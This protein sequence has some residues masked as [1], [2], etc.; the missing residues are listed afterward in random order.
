MASI[1]QKD[2]SRFSFGDV[3]ISPSKSEIEAEARPL[4]LGSS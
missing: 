2:G 1:D 4:L 3:L